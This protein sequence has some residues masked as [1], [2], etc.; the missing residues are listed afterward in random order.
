M[1]M[2]ETVLRPHLLSA[3][4]LR[5]E[6]LTRDLQEK[7]HHL[8]VLNG[9]VEA[10]TGTDRNRLLW[11]IKD[12]ETAV[13]QARKNLGRFESPIVLPQ[14]ALDGFAFKFKNNNKV[15]NATVWVKNVGILAAI[16]TFS[17]TVSVTFTSDYS[18]NPPLTSNDTFPMNAAASSDIQTR[19]SIPVHHRRY[20]IRGTTRNVWRTVYVRCTVVRWTRRSCC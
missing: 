18:P 19:R 4:A 6:T 13:E 7:E 3:V 14:L 5:R 11:M 20:R 1:A 9:E 15:F 17:V 12:Q 8:R 10:I 16:G 2:P